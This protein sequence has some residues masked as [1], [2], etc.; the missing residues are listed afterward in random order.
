MDL[1]SP[2]V[3]SFIH[4]ISIEP[5]QVHYLLPT[6]HGYCAGVAVTTHFG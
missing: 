2:G 5:L 4:S 3:H 1:D 6:Q